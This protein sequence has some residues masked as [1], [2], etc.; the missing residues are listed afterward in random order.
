MAAILQC[1]VEVTEL[2]DWLETKS[3]LRQR[4]ARRRHFSFLST[5]LDLAGLLELLDE[6]EVGIDNVD[7]LVAFLECMDEVLTA[8]SLL[9]EDRLD[10]K[11]FP[12]VVCWSVE[13][14]P[15]SDCMGDEGESIV[16]DCKD[17]ETCLFDAT[18]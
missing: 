12:D 2:C 9:D 1:T 5:E 3:E 13:D 8:L 10:N 6:M 15:I 14:D 7:V 18:C 17:G 16:T 4:C 11:D